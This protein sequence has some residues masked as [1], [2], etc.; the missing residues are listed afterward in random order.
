VKRSENL[1]QQAQFQYNGVKKLADENLASKELALEKQTDLEAAR[2]QTQLADHALKEKTIRSPLDGIVVKRY[3]EP[4]ESVDR[5]EKLFDIV[6]IDRVYIQFYLDPK[7]IGKVAVGEKL[8]MRFPTLGTQIFEASVSFVDPRIDAASG[9]FRVKLLLDNPNHDIKAG[10][11][12]T[13][14][15]LFLF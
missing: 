11:R 1:V 12:G 15:R 13:Q 9:L 14:G 10:M 6:N 4:G 3:K 2:L 7:M 8:P 5:T